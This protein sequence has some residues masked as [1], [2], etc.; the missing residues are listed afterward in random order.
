MPEPVIKLMGGEPVTKLMGGTATL[1]VLFRFHLSCSL[2][3][4]IKRKGRRQAGNYGKPTEPC[5]L[6]G[7]PTHRQE[8]TVK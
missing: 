8:T 7:I 3:R 6:S 5:P 4:L 1:L 2:Q